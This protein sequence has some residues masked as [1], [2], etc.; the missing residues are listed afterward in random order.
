MPQSDPILGQDLPELE[1]DHEE[2]DTQLLLHSKHAA[3][4]HDRII[5]KTPDTDTLHCNVEDHR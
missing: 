2:V 1:S 5:V 3:N 4:T